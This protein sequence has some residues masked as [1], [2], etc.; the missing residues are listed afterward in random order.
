MASCQLG[1]KMEPTPAPTCGKYVKSTANF[2]RWITANERTDW[3]TYGFAH[4]HTGSE[5]RSR[6][7]RKR[8]DTHFD[9]C[10]I[11]HKPDTI[12]TRWRRFGPFW[13]PNSGAIY[14]S[15]LRLRNPQIFTVWPLL[16]CYRANYSRNVKIIHNCITKGRVPDDGRPSPKIPHTVYG[17]LAPCDLLRVHTGVYATTTWPRSLAIFRIFQRGQHSNSTKPGD[18]VVNFWQRFKTF[19]LATFLRQKQAQSSERNTNRW[20]HGLSGNAPQRGFVADLTVRP[21]DREKDRPVLPSFDSFFLL[22]LPSRLLGLLLLPSASRCWVTHHKILLACAS[23]PD[24]R[25]HGTHRTSHRRATRRSR[26][27]V[28]EGGALRDS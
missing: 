2:S 19:T 12:P 8:E 21:T 10:K 14:C 15:P 27:R 5:S 17:S 4:T 23:Q 26:R 7:G 11:S 24:G 3:P 22:L 28:S 1:P 16:H 6:L 25:R 20:N 13:Y 18:V 9:R